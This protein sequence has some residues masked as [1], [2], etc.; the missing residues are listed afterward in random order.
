MNTGYADYY[1]NRANTSEDV[2]P[3]KHTAAATA[4]YSKMSSPLDILSRV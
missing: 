1:W 2:W 4:A 3:S